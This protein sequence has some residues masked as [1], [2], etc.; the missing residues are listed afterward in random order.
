MVSIAVD[1]PETLRAFRREKWPMPWRQ[2]TISNERH[3][4]LNKQL[5]L[6]GVPVAI[7]L[8]ADGRVVAATPDL[9]LADVPAR[10][11]ALAKARKE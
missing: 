1:P 4:A 10:L 7:L 11:E 9:E 5:G 3:E 2:A 6:I 8:D